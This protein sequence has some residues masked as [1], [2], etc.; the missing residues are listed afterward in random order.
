MA[1]IEGHNQLCPEKL[2]ALDKG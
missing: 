1:Y 2:E